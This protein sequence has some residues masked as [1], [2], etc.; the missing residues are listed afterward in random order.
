PS[1][2]SEIRTILSRY[3]RSVDCE[4]QSRAT[5]FDKLLSKELDSV[6]AGVVERMPA[7]EY[8]DVPY[9]EYVLNPTAMRMKALTLIRRP[10]IQPADL[11]GGATA[12]AEAE[13]Q[14]AAETNKQSVMA[15]LLNLM[16][17]APSAKSG[18][19]SPTSPPTQTHQQAPPLLSSASANALADLLGGASISPTA[20]LSPGSETA[21]NFSS[22][23]LD[24]EYEVY[25]ANGIRI[26]LTPSKKQKAPAIVEILA[27][28]YNSS[29]MAISDLNFLVAVPKSQKLQIMPPS[30][31]H[32]TAGSTVTQ[33]VKIANPSKTALRLRMKLAFTTDGQK[34][35]KMFDYAGFPSTV[36]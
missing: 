19:M 36:V 27:T 4:I 15:D 20:S 21:A 24:K 31:Q 10:A 23:D 32:I 16:D 25:N 1:V 5:E 13:A 28:F 6:R 3:E 34:I 2:A 17:D 33:Q 26:T 8:S 12:S 35:E 22:A 29:E 14:K 30:G 9:E 11:I 18:P 7:P